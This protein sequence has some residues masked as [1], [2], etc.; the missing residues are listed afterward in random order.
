MAKT[1]NPPQPSNLAFDA[2]LCAILDQKYQWGFFW[3]GD[4]TYRGSEFDEVKENHILPFEFDSCVEGVFG[5]LFEH[6]VH[7]RGAHVGEV[8]TGK[9][10]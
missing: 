6:P 1:V 5:L 3:R 9:N 4:W 2:S 7:Q 8:T 10:K